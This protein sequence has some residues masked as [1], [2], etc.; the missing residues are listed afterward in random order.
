MSTAT[1]MTLGTMNDDIEKN[2]VVSYEKVEAPM[3]RLAYWDGESH[4]IRVIV[5][6]EL[7]AAK[8]AQFHWVD[9]IK[10]KVQC[11]RV[12]RK[13]DQD[14][15]FYEGECLF[16]DKAKAAKLEMDFRS[17]RH[18][19]VA[20]LIIEELVKDEKGKVVPVLKFWEPSVKDGYWAQANGFYKMLSKLETKYGTISAIWLTVDSDSAMFDDK[21]TPAQAKKRPE[22]PADLTYFDPIP[23]REALLKLAEETGEGRVAGETIDATPTNIM[24]TDEELENMAF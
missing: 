2:V 6:T 8:V 21:V 4:L 16:C 3:E 24:P 23:Y 18:N 10:R 15:F 13:N 1:A 7:R 17:Y 20:Q 19:M 11:P 5:P 14:R 22:I 9:E 12:L